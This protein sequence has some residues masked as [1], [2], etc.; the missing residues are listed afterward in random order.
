VADVGVPQTVATRAQRVHHA[1]DAVAGQPED[2]VHAPRHEALDEQVG[3]GVS[4]A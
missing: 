4:H 1:V 2:G 3:G